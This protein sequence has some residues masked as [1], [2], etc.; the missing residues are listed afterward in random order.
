MQAISDAWPIWRRTLAGL[1]IGAAGGAL[2]V[3]LGIPVPWLLGAMLATTALTLGGVRLGVDPRLRSAMLLVIGVLI[4]S[5]FEQDLVAQ[6]GGWWWSLAAL[7][8]Y[9]VVI[10]AV[11][12]AY[13]RRVAGFDLKTAY[14]SASPGGLGEMILLADR[15]GADVRRT[16]LVHALRVLLLV[17]AIP[18]LVDRLG[19]V[20]AEPASAVSP[21]LAET[22]FLLATGIAG[23]LAARLV[24]LPNAILL[25][26]M[27]ASA[28][29]H[30]LGWSESQPPLV[31]VALAQV[32]VG[33]SVGARFSGLGL[34]EVIRTLGHGAVIT[35]VMLVLSAAFAVAIHP[36]AGMGLLTLMIAY[37]PGGV[38]EMALVAIALG[39]D[40]AYVST[41][42]VIRIMLV[43]SLA[44]L[45][46]RWV[47][48]RA[49]R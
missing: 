15:Y 27:L 4:G 23:F 41:H 35:V 40:P 9:V 13:L 2:F 28:V 30:V 19:L 14:F 36:L 37:V 46:A 21:S 26:P 39:I 43:V 5:G 3:A 16:S 7:P 48:G 45:L 49:T 1:A 12:M 38:A 42:H 29:V 33:A 11:V 17:T 22:A 47:Q 32:V 6:I 10:A 8:V 25:G 34:G 18:L 31:V 20:V 24:R 44:A